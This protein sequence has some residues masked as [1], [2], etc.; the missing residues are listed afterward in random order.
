MQAMPGN[1]CSANVNPNA[2]A[3]ARASVS[4]AS[5]TATAAAAAL[6]SSRYRVLGTSTGT[7]TGI[8]TSTRTGTGLRRGE[9]V[10]R[11]HVLYLDSS[12]T[13]D[14]HDTV[15]STYSTEY[16][17]SQRVNASLITNALVRPVRSC[18]PRWEIRTE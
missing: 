15:Q 13:V 10:T 18:D 2:N 3:N 1:I 6:K 14:R 7:S 5:A 16:L 17:A 8:G 9:L 11:V 12:L 4:S